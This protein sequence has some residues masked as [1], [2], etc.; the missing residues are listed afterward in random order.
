MTLTNLHEESKDAGQG[1]GLSQSLGLQG[2]CSQPSYV[3]EHDTRLSS[4]FVVED[5]E[6]SSAILGFIIYI[7]SKGSN[8]TFHKAN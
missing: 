5:D 3:E 2:S 1:Y 8:H 6:E 7:F 4:H